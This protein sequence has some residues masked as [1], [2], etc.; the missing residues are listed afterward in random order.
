[1]KMFNCSRYLVNTAKKA[2]CFEQLNYGVTKSR[3]DTEKARY[4]I[5]FLFSSGAI[6]EVAY[7]TTVLKFE[8]IEARRIPKSVL[9]VMKSHLI[10]LI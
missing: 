10:M 3:F 6:Q 9:T 4:F 8:E 2:S 7:E 5:D 1:M